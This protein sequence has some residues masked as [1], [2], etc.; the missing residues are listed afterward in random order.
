MGQLIECLPC[1][2][3]DLSSILEPPLERGRVGCGHLGD[4]KVEADLQARQPSFLNT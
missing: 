2:P 3:E 4:G 1:N